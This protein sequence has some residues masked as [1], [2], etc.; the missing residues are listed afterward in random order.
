MANCV[1]LK[2]ASFL[3]KKAELEGQSRDPRVPLTF[4]VHSSGA[5]TRAVRITR[6]HSLR[7]YDNLGNH[8][9]LGKHGNWDATT[10]RVAV[11]NLGQQV[12]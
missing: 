4:L 8:E 10:G 6:V 12:R 7:C 2:E 5:T 9:H 3:A 1:R 11:P